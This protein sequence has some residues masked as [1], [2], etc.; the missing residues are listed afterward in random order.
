MMDQASQVLQHTDTINDPLR[1]TSS[2]PDLPGGEVPLR[3]GPFA[4]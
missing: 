3:R 1:C 4:C 2:A